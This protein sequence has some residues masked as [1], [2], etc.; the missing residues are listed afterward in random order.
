MLQQP[1]GKTLRFDIPPVFRVEDQALF[2]GLKIMLPRR[3]LSKQHGSPFSDWQTENPFRALYR[4]LRENPCNPRGLTRLNP[5]QSGKE[6]FMLPFQNTARR[7]ARKGTRFQTG[8][9]AAQ[10]LQHHTHAPSPS[11]P[12]IARPSGG[13][14]CRTLPSL[15]P[16]Q[17]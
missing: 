8:Y 17:R 14:C 1:V 9:R 12:P 11:A 13:I 3:R 15:F 7:R 4:F 10:L 2:D 5:L 6:A 16:L